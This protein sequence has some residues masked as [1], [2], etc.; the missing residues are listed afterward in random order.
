MIS[1]HTVSSHTVLDI[2]KRLR[3][4]G[5]GKAELDQLEGL[6]GII[7]QTLPQAL[8]DF[9]LKISQTPEV[10]HFFTSDEQ[11]ANASSKQYEHWKKIVSGRFGD[12]YFQ[13]VRR[14]GIT[15]ARIGLE[16]RWY[17]AGNSLIIE[18]IV[19]AIMRELAESR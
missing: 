4:L 16:P 17:I 5:L 2:D 12:D 10:S 8:N 15:H 11:K 13:D 1:S 19:E 6:V 3:F 14:I 7:S 18:H 9:Y